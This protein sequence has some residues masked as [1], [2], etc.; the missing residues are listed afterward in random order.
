MKI[1]SEK[2]ILCYECFKYCPVN[3][4]REVDGTAEID[5]DLCVECS[6][7]LNVAV[8]PVDAI[9]MP[10]ESKKYPRSVRA[11]FSN[12][13]VWFPE[14]QQ[15]GRGTE[16]MKTNDVT[17]KFRRGEYGMT[18]EFGRPA[19]GTRLSEIEKILK[20]LFTLDVHLEEGNPVYLLIDD[21]KTGKLK[22]EVA[23]E[24]V[25]SAIVEFKFREEKLEEVI[26]AIRPVI[27]E[28]DTL[29]SWGLASRFAEDGTL[30]VL[31]ELKESG[32]S[33]RPNAKINMGLGRPMV[34]E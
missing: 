28:V 7:C 18:L 3:A 33:P 29:V 12:P 34:E 16:E 27:D 14:F 30:P 15:G 11:A 23:N 2:C 13:A 17:G 21:F 10:E 32:F 8:C 9:F 26:K 31:S 6:V 22:P 4:F 25:L 5:Q 24:R 19:T 20:V 1:D